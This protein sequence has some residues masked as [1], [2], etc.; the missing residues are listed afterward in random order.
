M[1]S[2]IDLFF[3]VQHLLGIGHLRRAQAIARRAAAEGL[4]VLFVS[5]G[6]TEPELEVGGAELLRLQPPIRTE[7]E[8]F[9]RLVTGEGRPVDAAVEAERRERLLALFAEHRPRVLL[10]EMFPFGR[11]Q[12]RFE[13]LPL[14]EA[15]KAAPWRPAVVSSV[16]DILTTL[17]QPGKVE[18]ILEV[19][20]RFYDRVLVHGD[21]ALVPFERTFPGVAAIT[22][23]LRYTGYVVGDSPPAAAAAE[24]GDSGE[25]LVSTG[26]GAVAEP[27]VRAALAARALSPLA[28]APW[29]VLIGANL[30]EERFRALAAAAP[31]GVTVERSRPDFLTLLARCRLSISQAG[32]NTTL[33]VLAAGRPALVVPFAAGAETEQTLRARLL[34]EQGRLAVVEEAGLTPE[35][36]AAGIARALALP[37]APALALRLGGAAETARQLAA[38]AAERASG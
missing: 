3:Y 24:G 11:R 25:V 21:P 13:L 7:D 34:E 8:N 18:W 30:P 28:D 15:A 31:P 1:A 6:V 16:R 12:M 35:R 38:L 17:K 23:R 33:E 36:L 19:V 14:V 9:S 20:A 22:E 2:G 4:T 26:G 29:R 5:G 10:T 32:Y 27:L 37:P